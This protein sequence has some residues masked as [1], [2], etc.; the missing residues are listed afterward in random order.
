MNPSNHLRVALLA[1]VATCL[2]TACGD[3]TPPTDTTVE[4][5]SF[6][7]I[8]AT[9]LATTCATSGCHTGASVAGAGA[10]ALDK[11]NAYDNL[12]GVASSN[13]SAKSDGM[14][15]V[16]AGD[17]EKSFLHWKLLF[18]ASPAGRDYGG[19]MPSGGQPI[20]NGEIEFIRR[21]IAAGA[22]RRGNV[23]D[24]AVLADRSRFDPTSFTA[25]APPA[26]GH[27]LHI[28]PFMVQ[29]NFER[30]IFLYQRVGNASDVFV[31]R[32]QTK[33]RFG[34]HHLLAYTFR[35]ETPSIGI[36][37]LNVVRDIRN[38]N[39]SMN[40][41][42]M[43]PMAYHVFL[44]GS[45]TPTSDYTFPPG[46]ALRIPANAAL[47]LNAHYANSLATSTIGEAYMNLH[48]TSQSQ[49]TREAKTLDMAN[50]SF[51]LAP[52]QRTTI[53]KSFTV[54]ATTTVFMLTSHMH[55]RGEKFVIRIKGGARNGEVVYTNTE[56]EH[57]LMQ[58][59]S[60]PIVLQPGEGLTSE[61]TYNN[62]TDRV[63][64]FGLTSEDEMGII[65]GY[66]Y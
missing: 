27:Q 10:L 52:R 5:S 23:A 38:P 20:T 6:D 21:W 16:K 44:A 54:S 40:V 43:I 22:P 51:S 18:H 62:E 9:T 61:I 50:T 49:V 41:L 31:N 15:R 46:V 3:T 26:Q 8:Q 30:E 34:S 29:P 66:Y 65:F 57:P 42:N 45:M 24:T 7:R 53:V 12:V 2:T 25:L 55:K 64:T 39:G 35:P 60:A 36:P 17:P 37:Q 58:N 59:Y 4:F 56:W 1:V 33:M 14:L 11:A 48:T 13:L 63:I 47:D 19:P 32:I 28:P